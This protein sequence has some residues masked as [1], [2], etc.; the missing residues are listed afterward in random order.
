MMKITFIKPL[1]EVGSCQVGGVGDAC[2]ACSFEEEVGQA[3]CESTIFVQF[4]N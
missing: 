1:L 2:A 3:S 4:V